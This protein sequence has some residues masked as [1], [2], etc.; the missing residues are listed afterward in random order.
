M[1]EIKERRANIE[2]LA[3]KGEQFR[4]GFFAATAARGIDE[5]IRLI[6]SNPGDE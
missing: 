3:N 6:I 4:N 1:A 5:V 2:V